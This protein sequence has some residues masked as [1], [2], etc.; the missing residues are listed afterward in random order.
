MPSPV[1][2]RN[3][4]DK[5]LALSG[6][7]ATIDH[8]E[9][10]PVQ[11]KNDAA[12]DTPQLRQLLTRLRSAAGAAMVGFVLPGGAGS[13][14]VH[15]KLSEQPS[16]LDFGAIAD[17]RTDN[18]P[19]LQHAIDSMHRAGG[20][21][22]L[23]P[24][25]TFLFRT[26]ILLRP[27]VRLQG[28]GAASILHF[29]NAARGNALYGKGMQGAPL[30]GVAL[31]DFTVRGD[32]RFARGTP[33]VIN[34]CGVI[35]T[36]ADECETAGLSVVGFSDAG[37]AFLDGNRNSVS[38]CHVDQT[39]QGISFLASA[40]S[41]VGNIA[42]GNRITRTG[43]Y[44][45]LHLE[46]GFGGKSRAEVRHT[47]L[48]GNTVSDSWEAGINIELA[49]YTSCVGNTVERSGQGRSDIAMGIKVYGG[50]GS[51]ICG[52]TVTASSGFG[53]VIGANSGDCA[54][55][56]NVT[57]GNRGALLLTDSGA[58]VSNDVAIGVNAFT[59]GDIETAGNV[60]I[61]SRIP[62]IRLRNRDDPDPLALDWYEE[63][64]FDPAAE[65]DGSPP[66]PSYTVRDGRFTRIGNV[67]HVS[68]SLS[69]RSQGRSGALRIT[70]LPYTAAT[71]GVLTASWRT[72][73]G[74]EAGCARIEP[75][76]RL[77]TLTP[78]PAPQGEC[79]VR[80]TGQY[81]AAS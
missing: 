47:S 3:F 70:G 40:V 45:G 33:A 49:P 25:G 15:R 20:G 17:D 59:E 43:E 26:P 21:T 53:L 41:V 7:A 46:G 68:I 19:A 80:V 60:R 32:A 38:H 52:N 57:A 14:T 2:R 22:L 24:A 27:H 74:E 63:G 5:G 35:L 76:E 48:V 51:A 4:L 50:Y 62:S 10:K 30:R 39:A 56:G 6:L 55:S 31:R 65:G 75:R 36:F 13:G 69:W 42:I 12:A 9:A 29:V 73:T 23:I 61:R 28:I 54:V 44:N 58:Q 8:A 1:T 79:S 81:L 16:I 37:I 67:V 78:P 71:A 18:A 11:S 34:G 66:P 64:R 72:G 77:L